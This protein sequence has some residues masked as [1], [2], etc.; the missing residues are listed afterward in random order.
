MKPLRTIGRAGALLAAAALVSGAAVATAGTAL[1]AT[2][3]TANTASTASTASTGWIRL[4]HL[5]PDT[6]AVDVYLYSFGNAGTR[7]VLHHVTYGTV[8]AYQTVPAGDYSIAMRPAGEAA[9]SPP[10]LSAST[11][12][13]AGAA[14]TAAA[15]GP[16]SGLRLQV[17]TDDL[18]AP[19]GK[20]LVRV[21]QASLKQPQVS[22]SWDGKVIASA[23]KFPSVT[24]YQAVP[25]G[26]EHVT[27]SAGGQDAASAVTLGAGSID[28]LVVLDGAKGLE[29]ASLQ[30]AAGSTQQPKGGAATGFGG[31]APHGPGSPLPWL[32]AMAAGALLAAGGGL[33]FLR[34]RR[35][36]RPVR[37]AARSARV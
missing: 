23:L 17:L 7:I 22:V 25:P 10:M 6:P 9:S 12:V 30:D 32:A 3:S 8:S 24:S 18:T 19:G 27:A 37:P 33:G 14:Y 1:A 4:A 15:V 16:A 21:V 34:R 36:P 28:T 20:A 5:A 29:V 26:T 31:T 2:A 11:W 13:K 35:S